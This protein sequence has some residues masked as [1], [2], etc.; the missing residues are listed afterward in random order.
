MSFFR[1]A[2]LQICYIIVNE[3]I[4]KRGGIENV[5]KREKNGS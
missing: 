5:G 1:L 4:I 2:Y 3:P